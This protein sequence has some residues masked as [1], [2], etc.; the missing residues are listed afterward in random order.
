[1]SAIP[2]Y[3]LICRWANEI[4]FSEVDNAGIFH[5]PDAKPF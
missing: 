3:L 2:L 1:M 4:D 5:S